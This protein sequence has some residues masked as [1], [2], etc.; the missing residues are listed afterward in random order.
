MGGVCV[1]VIMGIIGCGLLLFRR[2]S[3]SGAV[4]GEIGHEG[5][6][7][8]ARGSLGCGEGRCALKRGICR[9]RSGRSGRS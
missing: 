3:G 6:D 9:R 1:V 5:R 4:E 2:A 8:W 7:G